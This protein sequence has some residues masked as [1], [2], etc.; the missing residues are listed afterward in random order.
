MVELLQAM[1]LAQ[2][3]A[4]PA[5]KLPVL[6]VHANKDLEMALL[7]KA[8]QLWQA[9]QFDWIVLNGMSVA[10]CRDL[11]I[12]YAGVEL[13][14]EWLRHEGGIPAGCITSVKP[15]RHTYEE[16]AAIHQLCEQKGWSALAF[17]SFPYHIL[18]C[19]LT[20]LAV[21]KRCHYHRQLYPVS[22]PQV[23][24]SEPVT[25]Q[26]LGGHTFTR[27]RLEMFEEEWQ[28]IEKYQGQGDC[29]SLQEMLAFFTQKSCS[30][31]TCSALVADLVSA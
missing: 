9:G 25:K 28:R 23:D 6:F 12:N 17:L 26:F 20:Q 11:K 24:W 1:G 31:Q 14:E 3:S 5:K 7:E 29:V 8:A 4:L 22:L 15:G 30:D 16:A 21:M 10:E 18:R 27:P 13:W 2:T 19:T